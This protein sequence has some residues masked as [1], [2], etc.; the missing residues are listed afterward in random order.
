MRN[1]PKSSWGL[2]TLFLERDLA[3]VEINPLVITKQGDLICLDGKL[4][5]DGNALFRQPE[6]REMRDPS[7]EDS[8]EAHAAQWELNYVALDGN[9]GCMVNGAGLAMGTMDIVKLH[10]G[11]PANFL[12]VGG[13]A[14][15]ERVTEAFKIILS[16]DKVKAVFVNIFGGIVRCDLIADGIIGA[17]A[18]V[19]LACRLWYVLKETMRNWVPR[20][21]RI[22]A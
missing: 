19:A 6:L 10:G 18:E 4:G 22:A 21:W 11:S 7:Q 15:K 1:S 9:I 12:D 20:N 16:D 17:V 8:R 14:T 5:A 2:A 3:L 13:G